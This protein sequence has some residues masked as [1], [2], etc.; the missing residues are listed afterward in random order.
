VGYSFQYDEVLRKRL[1]VLDL[2]RWQSTMAM[3]SKP[4]PEG[5]TVL[6]CGSGSTGKSTFC[7]TSTNQLLAEQTFPRHISESKAGILL[8][9]LDLLQPELTPPGLIYLAHVKSALFGSP[10]SHYAIPGSSQSRILRMH[11]LGG[12]DGDSVSG[13]GVNA[14][15]DLLQYCGTVRKGHPEYTVLINSSSWLLDMEHAQLSSLISIMRPSDIVYFDSSGSLKYRELLTGSMGDKC[16]LWGLASKVYRSAP[17]TTIQWSQ[18][19]SYFHF[20]TS[21]RDVPNWDPLA[22]LSFNKKE[23]SYSGPGSMIWAIVTVGERLAPGNLAQ[24]LE[25]SIVAI[26]VVKM[27]ESC[28]AQANQ[29]RDE[30]PKQ[31]SGELT[32]NVLDMID[33]QQADHAYIVRTGGE[34][35]P[36]FL[37]S[38]LEAHFLHPRRS[39]C[40]G[41]AYITAVDP[42]REIIEVITP[43]PQ[44]IISAQSDNGLGVVIVMGRQDR[45]WAPAHR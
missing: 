22:P 32:Q 25:D 6:V 10:D 30:P 5:R 14:I 37:D 23:L 18:M 33:E 31:S 29:L 35:L 16:N 1:K 39:E 17:A 8:L 27:E 42:V 43:I 36:Y 9:D 15:K 38:G 20:L 44:Q 19:Q 4:L 11:Y 45:G 13:T 26:V 2:A 41:L 21:K 24:A 7:R 34:N 3:I 12:I 40:L 28:E